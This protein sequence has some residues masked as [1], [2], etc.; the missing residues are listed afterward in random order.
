LDPGVVLVGKG[1]AIAAVETAVEQV[2]DAI[3]IEVE[4]GHL[5]PKAIAACRVG[6]HKL[7]IH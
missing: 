2:Q 6:A 5:L 1:L 7:R 4:V 3:G